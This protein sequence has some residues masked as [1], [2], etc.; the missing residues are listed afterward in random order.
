MAYSIVT[1]NV[2]QPAHITFV[3]LHSIDSAPWQFVDLGD[4]I[5]RLRQDLRDHLRCR[6]QLKR[7]W[8]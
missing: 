4:V 2:G 5:G 1:F 3:A 8:V 7:Q 6:F